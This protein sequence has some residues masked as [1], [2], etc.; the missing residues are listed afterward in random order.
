MSE[1]II[2][3][4]ATAWGYGGIAIVRL[5]GEGCVA[6]ADKIYT[7]K[8]HRKLSEEPARYMALGTLRAPNGEPFDEVLAVR[9]ERGKS[10][11]GEEAAE[12]HCHGGMAAAQRCV[13]ELCRNGARLALPGE[14]T[15][16]AFVNGR[17]D[18]AQAEAVAGIIKAQ[19]DEALS[20]SARALQGEFTAKIKKL[21][22]RLTELYAALEVDLDFPEEGEGF[23]AKEESTARLEE[24]SRECGELCS[25]CRCGMLL[26]DGLRA[27]IIGAPNVGKSSLLNALLARERAI[28]TAVPGTTRDSI[29]ETFICGGLPVRIIDTAGIRDTEDEVEAIGVGRSLRSME[30]ADIVLRVLDGAEEESAAVLPRTDKPQI[31]VINKSDLPQ[32]ITKEEAEARFPGSAV[33]CVSAKEG[34]GIAELKEL[35]LQ[36]AAAGCDVSQSYSVSARQLECLSRA[37]EA[38]EAASEALKSAAGEDA[39]LSC[40]SEGAAQLASL[41]GLDAGEELLDKIFSAFC[42]GK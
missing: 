7:S 33:L 37:K 41:L 5:S 42:V 4:A 27:A 26:R 32:R 6:A 14:F 15:R 19:S 2:T 3:T 24:L 29:E 20:A 22:A 39:A 18:L 23:I 8:T 38:V 13:A 25:R 11:T 12:L 16:R 35:I 17:I 40:V 1:E 30:E 36:T 9:F 34:C 31:I 28:V 10:Y 21:A